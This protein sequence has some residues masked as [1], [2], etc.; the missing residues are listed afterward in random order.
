MTSFSCPCEV[1]GREGRYRYLDGKRVCVRCVPIGN[2]FSAKAF[3]SANN[4]YDK[5][6]TL[7][8]KEELER[9][10]GYDDKDNPIYRDTPGKRSYIWL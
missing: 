7:A 9:T 10:D 8:D 6:E 1:C 2:L 4:P 3:A 5:T